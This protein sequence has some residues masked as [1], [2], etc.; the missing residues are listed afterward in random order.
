[1]ASAKREAR[2]E[3]NAQYR[4]H[5]VELGF[6]GSDPHVEHLAVRRLVEL[7]RRVTVLERALITE[8]DLGPAEA[9]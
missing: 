3:A 9:S 2:K 4:R 1:M 8:N 5:L 6:D 7:Q